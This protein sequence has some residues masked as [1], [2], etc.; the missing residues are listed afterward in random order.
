MSKRVQKVKN[1]FESQLSKL[2]AALDLGEQLIG[3]NHFAS[4]KIEN[5]VQEVIRARDSLRK[6]ISER[7]EFLKGSLA[8]AEF[9]MQNEEVFFSI[10]T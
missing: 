2:E 10:I 7:E 1:M 6:E 3:D 5:R 8:L 4:E 9:R